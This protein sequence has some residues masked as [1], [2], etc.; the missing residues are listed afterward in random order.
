M[1]IREEVVALAL[2]A[3]R[4]LGSDRLD[5]IDPGLLQQRVDGLGRLCA[6]A[7]PMTSPF[8]IDL[9]GCWIGNGIVEPDGLNEGPIAGRSA[10]S[11]N[12]AIARALLGAHSPQ[13]KFDH[14]ELLL[15]ISALRRPHGLRRDGER[16]TD[17]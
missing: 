3:L 17:Q 1:P 9:D 2:P 7:E 6:N 10:I 8:E 4:L 14:A 13:A 11:G 12:N 5:A 16:M 15:Y